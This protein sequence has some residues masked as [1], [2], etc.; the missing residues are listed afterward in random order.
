MEINGRAFFFFLL[1][2]GAILFFTYPLM[3][4]PTKIVYL[5]NTTVID[6]YINVTITPTPDNGVYYATEEENGTRK[7]QRYYSYHRDNV[8]GF[9]DL[10]FHVTVYGFKMLDSYHYWNI[11]DGNWYETIPS[12]LGSKFLFVYVQYYTDTDVRNWLPDEYRFMVNYKGTVYTPIQ[13]NQEITIKE[14]EYTYT[15]NNDGII[16]YYGQY[17][18]TPMWGNDAGKQI[19]EPYLISYGGQS[20]AIDGYIVYEIPESAEPKDLS[21]LGS[22]FAFGNSEWLLK[23]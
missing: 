12:S 19:S 3:I 1:F 8:S 2:V 22:F 23:T 15:K 21:V 6:H 11:H 16:Q 9:K 7:L 4:P 13:F 14:L 17:V 10:D 18:R 5:N 20:N